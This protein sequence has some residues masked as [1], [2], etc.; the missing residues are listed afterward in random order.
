[1]H[2]FHA[3]NLIILLSHRYTTFRGR[4]LSLHVK[5]S[6]CQRKGVHHSNQTLIRG[7]LEDRDADS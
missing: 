5:F 4:M 7:D 3:S 2:S 6:G 1:M